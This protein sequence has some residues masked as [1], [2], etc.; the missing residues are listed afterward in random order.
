MPARYFPKG[1][2][3]G[4]VADLV[5]CLPAM[6]EA[7]GWSQQTHH[8]RNPNTQKAEIKGSEVKARLGETAQWIKAL[9][10]TAVRT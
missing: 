2:L 3:F 5:E 1:M 9:C 7:V 6:H 8:A 4:D 10:S